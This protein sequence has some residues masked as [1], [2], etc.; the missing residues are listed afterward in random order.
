MNVSVV[1]RTEQVL[2]RDRPQGVLPGGGLC[3]E[4]GLP[5]PTGHEGFLSDG[6]QQWEAG[7]R[8]VWSSLTSGGCDGAVE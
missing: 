3:E 8:L 7:G 5:V 2:Q 6:T 1:T 4:Q